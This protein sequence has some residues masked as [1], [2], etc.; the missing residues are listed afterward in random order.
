MKHIRYEKG[1]TLLEVL[2]ALA[3]FAIAGMVCLEGYLLS[4]KHV[5]LLNDNKNNAILARW[6]VE[7]LRMEDKKIEADNGI[8]P[9]PFEGYSWE[10][11]L[12]D[13]SIADTEYDVIFVP[14]SLNISN[15]KSEYEEVVPFI[16]IES[17]GI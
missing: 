7:E 15:G 10:I 11:S 17:G 5:R 6:K 12:S 9:Q 13:V 14:Y 1:F 16:K 3:I 4:V 8:F 2:I